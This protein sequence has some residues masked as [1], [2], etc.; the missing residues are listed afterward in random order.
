MKKA[1]DGMV[2]NTSFMEG[3]KEGVVDDALENASVFTSPVDEELTLQRVTKR[4]NE[5]Y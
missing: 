2:E 4:K 3:K 5:A 1:L